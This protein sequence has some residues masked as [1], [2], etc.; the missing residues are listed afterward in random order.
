M[1]V[2]LPQLQSVYFE[3]AGARAGEWIGVRLTLDGVPVVLV[4]DGAGGWTNRGIRLPADYVWLVNEQPDAAEAVVQLYERR[5]ADV[6][7][8]E[9][10]RKLQNLRTVQAQLRAETLDE[11]MRGFI[12]EGQAGEVTGWVADYALAPVRDAV[13]RAVAG[14]NVVVDAVWEYVQALRQQA[15]QVAAKAGS[16]LRI[17]K[18][19][20]GIALVVWV[21]GK[22]V[23]PWR[24]VA[25]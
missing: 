6:A 11:Y 17:V 24:K 2:E 16:A 7:S 13:T 22:A 12:W 9:F 25:A 14:W 8:G 5:S 1:K 15:A 10:E 21:A 20:A 3:A 19:G 4:A 23:R 18:W